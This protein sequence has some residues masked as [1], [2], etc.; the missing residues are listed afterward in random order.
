MQTAQPRQFSEQRSTRRAG[1]QFKQR[2]FRTEANDALPLTLKHER[3]YILPTARGIA[4]VAVALVMILASM[5]YGLNLGY[6]LSFILVGLFA[7]C[8]LSTYLNL[9]QLSINSINSDDTFAGSA[10]EYQVEIRELRG[11]SRYSI[12]LCAMGACS[13]LDIT[14][15]QSATAELRRSENSRGVHQ[16]GRITISSDFP[17]GL[18]RGWGYIHAVTNTYIY[19]RPESPATTLPRNS[20]PS[21]DSRRHPSE[22]REFD[23][24]KRYEVTD[25]LSAVAWKTVAQG[26]GWFS[27]EFNSSNSAKELTLSWASTEELQNHE[28]RLSRLCAWVLQAESTSTPYQLRFPNHVIPPAFGPQQ[29]KTCLRYLASF[30]P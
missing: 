3:I 30:E 6:A 17:L 29:Q 11:R 18:W 13:H 21:Q 23:Q 25:G 9:T 4:F 12:E 19:P 5:N 24:L 16:L 14:A 10:V 7:S 27:K 15:N 2:L 28:Q 1:T 26:R 22:E 20:T 8:L